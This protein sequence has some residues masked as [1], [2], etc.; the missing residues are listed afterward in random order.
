MTVLRGEGSVRPPADPVNG[1]GGGCE[2]VRKEDVL[3]P[4]SSHIAQSHPIRKI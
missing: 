3:N 2:L 4:I 1:E